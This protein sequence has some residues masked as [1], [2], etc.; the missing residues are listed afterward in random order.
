MTEK[1]KIDEGIELAIRLA[2]NNYQINKDAILVTLHT[3]KTVSISDEDKNYIG[4]LLN[5]GSCNEPII[6][7][8]YKYWAKRMNK[9]IVSIMNDYTNSSL[10]YIRPSEIVLKLYH[11][12]EPKTIERIESGRSWI[13]YSSQIKRK[14]VSDV[15]NGCGIWTFKT[16]YLKAVLNEK[17]LSRYG[18]SIMVL[19]TIPFCKYMKTEKEVIG[20]HYRV[21]YNGDIRKRETLKTLSRLL[22]TDLSSIDPESL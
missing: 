5:T 16:E 15:K 20:K 12:N 18:K 1:L 4:I 19:K 3:A 10:K 21:I 7:N 11:P 17:T 8:L 14:I 13:D 2:T 9:P 6:E 22:E